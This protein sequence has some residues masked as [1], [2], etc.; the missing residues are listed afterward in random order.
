MVSLASL[1]N[2]NPE[3]CADSFFVV[4]DDSLESATSAVLKK[5]SSH[6]GIRANVQPSSKLIADVS[7]LRTAWGYFT[8]GKGLS[9]AAYYRIYMAHRLAASGEFDQM[10]YID[11]DT[12]VSHGFQKL[13]ALP[14]APEVLLRAALDRVEVG[15]I[16]EA[17]RRHG[18]AEGTYFN[19]GILYFPNVNEALIE[20]LKEAER[21]AVERADQ[22]MFLDQC[23]LN[24]AFAGAND[25][26]PRRF[27][28][29]AAPRDVEEF[30]AVPAARA[31]LVHMTDRPK[32]WDS[33]Y[34]ND[35][36]I[37]QRWIDALCVLRHLVGDKLLQPLVK[38]TYC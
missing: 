4:V 8:A 27:N 29:F 5:F 18:L 33:V 19:S 37:K 17:T 13:F 34:P 35:T 23:A 14:T 9:P 22:L 21:L 28:Y 30:E 38:A 25:P 32:P 15:G 6:F 12:V 24:I 7:A 16:I 26:L 31:C 36:L 3:L 11:S 2:H 10:L 20:R 1:L